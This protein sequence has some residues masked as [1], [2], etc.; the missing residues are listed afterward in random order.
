MPNIDL[1]EGTLNEFDSQVVAPGKMAVKAVG[2]LELMVLGV[3]FGGPDKG[4]DSDGQYFSQKTSVHQYL[5]P[6]IP[7]IYYHGLDPN[8]R[9]MGDPEII[10]KA[11]YDHV[12]ADGHWWRV[13]LDKASPLARRIWEASKLGNAFAS[14]GSIGHLARLMV[15]GVKRMYD[16]FIKGEIINWPVV[17]LTLI[18]ADGKRQPAN[19]YAVAL[20]VT[21]SMY[22]RAGLTL[23]ESQSTETEQPDQGEESRP[24]AKTDNGNHHSGAIE[25]EPTEIQKMISDALK[26]DREAVKAEAQAAAEQQA[27]IDSAVAAEKAKWEAEAAKSR[28]LP[29]G[30]PLVA[31]YSGTNK[32]DH[33]STAE[34]GL[35][36]DM[37]NEFAVKTNKINRA[38]HDAVRALALKV[39]RIENDKVSDNTVAY[40][41][42]ALKAVMNGDLSDDAIKAATDPNY[43]TGSLVGS[44][45]VGTAYSNQIWEAIRSNTRVVAK[46]PSDVIPDGY[47][48]DTVPLESTDPKWYKVAEATANE[49]TLKI[50]QATVTASQVGTASKNITVGKMGARDVYTGEMNEDSLIAYVPNLK[51]QL[52]ISGSEMMEYVVIDGDTATSSNINDIGGTTYSGDATS[53][54]LLTNGFRKSCLVTTTANSR[55]AAGTLSEDDYLETMW[56]MG[57]AGMAGSDIAKCG[58]IIDPNVYKASLKMATLKTKDVWTQATMESGVLTKLWGYEVIPSWFMHYNSATRKANTAGKVD[59]DTT[60]NNLFGAILAVRWDQWRL[61]YKRRMTMETTR[62][63]NADAWEVVALTRWGLGQRDT[64]ASAISYYVGL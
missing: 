18:D 12:N 2:D 62:I 8:G 29:L 51:R 23:P 5:Y 50:P 30:M 37:Q 46:I 41:K 64:E 47:A 38:T 57:T 54:F 39:A 25:M 40:A 17:E 32:Y 52:E 16:K 60:T 20:P 55:S 13:A 33:L 48:S 26:A 34:L 11:Q 3:P 49:A 22:E 59:Q 61:K 44:D 10:G 4:R 7:V 21:K 27:K 19:K 6:T 28:R 31:Q 1:P 42:S 35:V 63:A 43:S 14:T 58:Y 9:P 56:L 53:L 36:I 45:W 24:A 15:N